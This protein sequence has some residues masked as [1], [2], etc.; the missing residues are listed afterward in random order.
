MDL[1]RDAHGV[2]QGPCGGY[3]FGSV[4][5]WSGIVGQPLQVYLEWAILSLSLR[6]DEKVRDEIYGEMSLV[7]TRQDKICCAIDQTIYCT[8]EAATLIQVQTIHAQISTDGPCTVYN[9]L[10]HNVCE[11]IVLIINICLIN[12]TYVIIFILA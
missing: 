5:K 2:D 11:V 1:S 10:Q 6:Y 3:S 7:R 9:Q 4:E 12:I 8:L